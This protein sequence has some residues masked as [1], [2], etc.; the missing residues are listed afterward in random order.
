MST[1]SVLLGILIVFCVRRDLLKHVGM[2][3][4]WVGDLY[5]T[6]SDDAVIYAVDMLGS[7]GTK[8]RRCDVTSATKIYRALCQ[9]YVCNRDD[10][11]TWRGH[12]MHA[13]PLGT[14]A[15]GITS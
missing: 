9:T 12:G 14:Q 8:S 13:A 2:G 4:Q 10:Y 1:S 7:H 3:D 15:L 5:V 6:W 11:L